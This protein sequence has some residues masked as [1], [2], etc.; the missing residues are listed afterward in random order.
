MKIIQQ[1]VIIN[2]N[3][4]LGSVFDF[5]I[6][7]GLAGTLLYLVVSV[8]LPVVI[9]FV[10]AATAGTG[11]VYGTYAGIAMH[12]EKEKAKLR[13]QEWYNYKND[14]AAIARRARLEIHQASNPAP[15]TRTKVYSERLLKSDRN[16]RELQ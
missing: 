15:Q 14:I 10:I 9:P 5:L 13:E 12:K 2:G 4:S 8:V 7:I 3:S 11:L 16:H 6:L 1:V